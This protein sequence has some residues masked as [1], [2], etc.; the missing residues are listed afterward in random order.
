MKKYMV[1]VQAIMGILLLL[2]YIIF[3]NFSGDWIGFGLLLMIIINSQIRSNFIEKKITFYLSTFFDLV[4]FVIFTNYF[5]DFSLSVF[6]YILVNISFMDMKPGVYL[7]F[8]FVF[9]IFGL[10]EIFVFKAFKLLPVL[11]VF[12]VLIISLYFIIRDFERI[13]KLNRAMEKELVSKT[14]RYDK[15]EES[16]NTIKDIYVLKER[17]RISRDLHDSVGHSLTTIIVQLGAIAKLSEKNNEEVSKMASNLKDFAGK[18]LKDIRKLIHDMRPDGLSSG[19]LLLSLEELFNVSRIKQ[20]LDI[21]FRTNRQAWK[22]SEDQELLIYRACQ[23]F[24]S[25]TR[26]YAKAS[27]VNISLIFTENELILTMKDN[28][29][30]VESINP[31]QGIRGIRE[32]VEELHGIFGMESS[33]GRGFMIR[34]VLKRVEEGQYEG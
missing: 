27:L 16:M 13:F 3:N 23:E 21:N 2:D 31:R 11:S 14:L 24:L 28:G 26:K 4:F 15:I 34:L 6:T 17:N 32:R 19:N 5:K 1:L 25:N 22:L 8:V 10:Y 18:G 33:P 30:G 12:F 20:G 9:L 7:S 29:Q